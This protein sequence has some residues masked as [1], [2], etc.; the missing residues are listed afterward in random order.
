MVEAGA[1]GRQAPAH[2]TTLSSPQPIPPEVEV[3]AEIALTVQVACP[4]GCDLR[5]LPVE[6]TASDSDGGVAVCELAHHDDAANASGEIRVDAPRAVGEQAWIVRFPRHETELAVH[7][8]SELPLRFRTVPHACS[9][10]AWGVPSPTPAGN[11]L[12]VRVGVRCGSGCGLGGARVAVCDE[13]GATVG[14][15]I[16]GETPW[17][18]TGAL[19]WAAVDVRAPAA[20]GV[21]AWTAV[22]ADAG[23]DLPHDGAP[24]PFGF[25]TGKACEHCAA[26]R[27]IDATSRTP[28]ADVEVRVGPY[29]AATAA[30]GVATVAVPKGAFEVSIRRDGLEARPFTVTVDGDLALD[31]EAAV[32]PKR[33][34]LHERA[35]RDFP[36][37]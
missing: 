27:V 35:I 7:E 25:R 26:V 9:L 8:E 5:G 23:T 6:I 29:M 12:H 2:P 10:T 16:L 32:V 4:H 30:D 19:Y 14:D 24:A 18:D 13:T 22:L 34:E 21:H 37:G 20:E 3:G 28:V 15:G 31:I 17:P 1:G 11:A 33:A 36:W